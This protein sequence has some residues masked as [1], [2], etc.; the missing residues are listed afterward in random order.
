MVPIARVA[1]L[2]LLPLL[3]SACAGE[4]EQAARQGAGPDFEILTVERLPAARERSWDGVVEAVHQ[5]TLSAQTGGR[6]LEL[7]YDVNDYVEAGEVVVRFTD[8][9]QQSGQR[10]AQ[11]NLSAAQA[12]FNEAEADFRR[13]SEVFGRQLVSRAQYDQ[14]VARR[15]SARAQ[16]DAARAAVREAGE[17]VD[18]T[19]VR[20]P[21]S[22]ILTERFVEVGETVGPGQPLVAGLSLD[23][24]RVQVEVPQSDIAAIR[25][26]GRAWVVLGD[27]RRVEAEQ[28][29][30]FPYADPLTHS[31]RVRLELPEADTGL[32]PGMTAKVAFML[33]RGERLGIPVSALVQRSEVTAVYVVD[34]AGRVVLRQIRPGHRFNDQVEVLAGLSDGERI[35]ADPL[36]AR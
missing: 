6:V 12:A 3:L 10:R 11:A 23:R 16:L 36:A 15:D 29:I 26:H 27:G 17:L 13:I 24:L 1:G 28:V 14:S 35:A 7:P 22:G 21:Y 30:V 9:E 18:Y 19:V 2:L 31:F 5:A 34:D 4:P 25:R 8:V 32:Q 20:A 33:D